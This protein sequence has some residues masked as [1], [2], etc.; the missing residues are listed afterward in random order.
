MLSVFCNFNVAAESPAPQSRD[1]S[2]PVPASLSLL[3]ISRRCDKVA[4]GLR[5][6]AGRPLGVSLIVIEVTIVPKTKVLLN[7]RRVQESMLLNPYPLY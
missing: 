6:L 5:V 4:G 2:V 3:V 7:H 1:V